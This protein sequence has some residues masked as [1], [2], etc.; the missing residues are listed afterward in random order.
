MWVHC[1]RDTDTWILT[2]VDKKE[3]SNKVF[4]LFNLQHVNSTSK[5]Q[6]LQRT[7]ISKLVA[8]LAKKVTQ[9]HS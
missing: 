6:N 2:R 8:L 3:E 7:F 5:I 4:S 1:L 9:S